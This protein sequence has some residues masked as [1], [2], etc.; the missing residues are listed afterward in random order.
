MIDYGPLMSVVSDH[1]REACIEYVR[2]RGQ[3]G[4]RKAAAHVML[5]FGVSSMELSAALADRG[6][7]LSQRT[8]IDE[9]LPEA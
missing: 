2:K 3:M 9:R 4:S 6:L 1:V 7:L 5:A 8:H